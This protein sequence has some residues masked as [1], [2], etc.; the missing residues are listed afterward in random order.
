MLW[1]QRTCIFILDQI[2]SG[3]VC[4]VAIPMC[5]KQIQKFLRH[6]VGSF[7]RLGARSPFDAKSKKF[8]SHVFEHGVGVVE[9][10]F[11]FR[12]DA[13]VVRPESASKRARASRC[14]ES[15]HPLSCQHCLCGLAASNR[16]GITRLGSRVERSGS[17]LVHCMRLVLAAAA[18]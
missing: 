11:R 13:V 8:V 18:A 3:S 15:A 7:G 17:V 1:G 10:L 5:S 2:W 14:P 6:Y 9:F 4:D 16:P 12:V